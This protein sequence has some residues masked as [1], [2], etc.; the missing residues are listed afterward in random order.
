MLGDCLDSVKVQRGD[1]Q[2]QDKIL[3]KQ[4]D[5]RSI[6]RPWGKFNVDHTLDDITELM[7]TLCVMTA[8]S[9]M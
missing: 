1:K 8:L 3:E 6:L 5:V 7:L 9:V 4:P 2:M